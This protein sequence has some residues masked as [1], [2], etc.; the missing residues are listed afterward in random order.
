MKTRVCRQESLFTR[1]ICV[2]ASREIPWHDESANQEGG[3][4]TIV[5]LGNSI[6]DITVATKLVKVG[7]RHFIL[8]V[9]VSNK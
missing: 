7:H 2:E 6:V 3:F 9:I 4:V 1:H 8:R 5:V